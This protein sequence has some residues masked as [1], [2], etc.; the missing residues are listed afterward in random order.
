MSAN[1]SVD[2]PSTGEDLQQEL[3]DLL[4]LAV[5]GDHLRWALT[6]DRAAELA[7]WLADAAAQW[8][9]WADEV[10]KRLVTVGVAPDGRVRSL[11]Q[12]IPMN[13]VPAGWLEV[14][15][16]RRLLA[17]RVR[18]VAGKAAYRR[19]QASDADVHRLL[20]GVRF[21][22]EEQAAILLGRP[23]RDDGRATARKT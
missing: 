14:E 5:V 18:S 9:A 19:S 17:G 1:T 23:L 2:Q 7:E 8:R 11:A 6:G 15:E 4:C 16:A 3:R 13:W 22:L 12:D 20:D 10:A 21:G